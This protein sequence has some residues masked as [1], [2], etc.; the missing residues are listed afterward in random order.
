MATALVIGSSDGIGLALVRAL[1]AA[2][3]RV[4]GVSR[5]PTE[6]EGADSAV[7]D[8]RA[9]G[10]RAELGELIDRAGPIDVCVYCAGVGQS[11]DLPA[12][13]PERETFE[14][15]LMGAVATAEV[16]VP[17]FLAAGAGHFVG[18][19]SLADRLTNRDAPAYSASKAGLTSY[20]EGLALACRPRGVHITN[21]RFGFVD[22]KM[23]RSDV[24]PFM[25]SAER[26][27]ARVMRCLRKRPIRYSSPRRMAF[28]LW[29]FGL[30]P[31]L[32]VWLS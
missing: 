23:A 4:I 28:L 30:G 27:A 22:T 14:V 13:E 15:N 31:R 18:L 25:I 24:R 11:L 7:L 29:F 19:S 26:A 10:Y 6:V 2:D 5:R 3:W 16:V 20:L 32:R 9:V 21:V 1:V 12:L 8:V 17:R